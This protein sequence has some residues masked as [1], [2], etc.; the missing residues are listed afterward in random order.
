MLWDLSSVMLKVCS[1]LADSGT[2]LTVALL[3]MLNDSFDDISK[4]Q[5]NVKLLYIMVSLQRPLHILLVT[6]QSQY[7]A[8]SP[9]ERVILKLVHCA[10]S[11]TNA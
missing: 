8:P 1:L 4:P 3:T 7:V 2:L 9:K 6:N 5:H 10:L 11:R